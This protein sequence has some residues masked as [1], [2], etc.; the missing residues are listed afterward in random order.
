MVGDD[1]SHWGGGPVP[2]QGETT[3]YITDAYMDNNIHSM[4]GLQEAE[5]LVIEYFRKCLRCLWYKIDNVEKYL[6][7]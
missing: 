3:V 7:E 4:C 1:L 5:I 6:K 2:A